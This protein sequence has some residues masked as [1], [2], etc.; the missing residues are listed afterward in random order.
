MTILDPLSG[1]GA[2]QVTIADLLDSPQDYE[3]QFIEVS[4]TYYQRSVVVCSTRPQLSPARWALSDGE[5][6]IPAG[7]MDEN[8]QK[9]PS[10]RI[11]L[12]VIG[13]WVRW[14]GPIGC[15][16]EAQVAEVWYLNVL[17]VISPNPITIAEVAS[18]DDAGITGTGLSLETPDP[19]QGY[20][21]PGETITAE[22]P[23]ATITPVLSETIELPGTPAVSPS[24]STSA[25]NPQSS[26]TVSITVTPTIT[27]TN[28]TTPTPTATSTIAGDDNLVTVDQED[29]PP[30][31]IESSQLGPNEIHRWPFVITTTAVITVNVASEI[32]LD[33]SITIRDSSGNIVAEQNEAQ[34]GA[35]EVMGGV[36]LTQ[37]GDYEILISSANETT[38]YYAILVLNEESYSFIF[39][40]TL[41]LG[42]SQSNN[43][44]ENNDHFW[45]FYGTAGQTVTINVTPS[46]ASNLFLRLFGPNDT[47]LVDFHDESDEGEPEE[48]VSFTLPDTG[49]YSLLIGEL[50]FGSA[51]YTITLAGG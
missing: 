17:D 10:G 34:D 25:P 33:A 13:R 12:A 31:S 3:G 36:L 26:P 35:P 16:R 37:P 42:D 20:P 44:N 5:N 51:A 23:S 7:G 48:L 19:D 24:P 45:Q 4:G 18:N 47:L 50:S 2:K 41:D 22:V 14:Q 30:G 38:G 27:D 21:G 46:D 11:D 6:R 49:I 28:N 43:L 32:P 8:L 39:N 1:E 15:G 29:L 40:G 9:L